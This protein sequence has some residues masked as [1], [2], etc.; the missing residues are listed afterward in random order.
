[1]LCNWNWQ[2]TVPYTSANLLKEKRNIYGWKKK[3]KKKKKER[4][5]VGIKGFSDFWIVSKGSLY[6]CE[7]LYLTN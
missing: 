5:Y 4:N 3:K 6:N 2:C 1:M 7:N